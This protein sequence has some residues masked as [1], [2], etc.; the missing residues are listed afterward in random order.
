MGG[1]PTLMYGFVMKIK[2][3]ILI[4]H[5]LRF[6]HIDRKKSFSN[7][8][9]LSL[10]SFIDIKTVICNASHIPYNDKTLKSLIK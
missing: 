6:T 9:M 2:V 3:H 7:L 4:S 5:C 8:N 10:Y 1:T